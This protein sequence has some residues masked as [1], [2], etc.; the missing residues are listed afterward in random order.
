MVHNYSCRGSDGDVCHMDAQMMNDM[1]YTKEG[2]LYTS[3]V[4]KTHLRF[5]TPVSACTDWVVC[6]AE[7]VHTKTVNLGSCAICVYC[8]ATIKTCKII[9]SQYGL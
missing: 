7:A 5:P 9:F 1:K 8:I 4:V 3:Q 2:G 6:Q